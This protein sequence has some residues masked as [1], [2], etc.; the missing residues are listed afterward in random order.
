ARSRGQSLFSTWASN[1]ARSIFRFCRDDERP[2]RRRVCW[3]CNVKLRN[4][5]TQPGKRCSHCGR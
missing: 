4:P 1:E 5:I 3:V 2:D